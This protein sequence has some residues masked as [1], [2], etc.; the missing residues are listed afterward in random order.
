MNGM[1][2]Q[3]ADKCQYAHGRHELRQKQSVKPGAMND[4]EKEKYIEK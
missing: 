4:E 2:C 3:F 1:Y